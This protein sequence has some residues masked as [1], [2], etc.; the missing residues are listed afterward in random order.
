LENEYKARS[1]AVNKLNNL[2]FVGFYDGS[3]GVYHLNAENLKVTEIKKWKLA[4]EWISDIKV[5]PD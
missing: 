5:S 4:N 2:I 1:I 3:L